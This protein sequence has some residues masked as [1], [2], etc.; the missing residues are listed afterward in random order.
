MAQPAVLLL[1]LGSPDSISV[2][3]VRRYLREFLW[4]ERVLDTPTPLRWLVLNLFILPTRPKNSAEA[5]AK[6]WTPEG[7]PLIATSKHVQSKVQAEVGADA[8]IALA[9]RYGNPSIASVVSQLRQAGASRVLVIPLYPQYAMSSYETVVALAEKTLAEQLPDVPVDVLP[10]FYEHPTYIEA[11]AESMRP[12][13]AQGFD[14]LLFSYHGIP[15]RHLQK[16]DPSHAHCLSRPDCCDGCHPAHQTCYR[17]QCLRVTELVTAKL[18]LRKKQ[19]EISFQS[20]LGSTPWLTPYTD[21][22]LRDLPGEGV[23]RLLVVCPAFV[24]DCLET[25]EEIA[26]RGHEIFSEAGGQEFALI[27]CLNEHPQWIAFLCDEIR[28]WLDQPTNHGR[29]KWKM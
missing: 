15:Y 1:N 26:M 28:Q 9:M 13:L 29:P 18:G 8:Q 22:R 20:R 16:S 17:H 25:L 23:K 27:P 6:V 14:K 11:L 21:Y 4:D 5:Y 3:D 24:S 12:H 2:A 7:S 10:P 19:F